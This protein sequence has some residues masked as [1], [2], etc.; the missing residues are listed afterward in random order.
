MSAFSSSLDTHP[1]AEALQLRLLRQ[2]A[3]GR[4]AALALS[5]S[6]FVIRASRRA[7]ARRHPELTERDRS[8]LWVELHYGPEL[9]GR[10]RDYLAARA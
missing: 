9:A 10:V 5:L 4:R 2:A 3:P 7:V 6:S 1:E 8:L